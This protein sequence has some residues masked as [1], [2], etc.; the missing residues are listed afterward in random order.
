MNQTSQKNVLLA[1]V[2]LALSLSFAPTLSAHSPFWGAKA[3]NQKSLID[4]FRNFFGLQYQL[5]SGW[6]VATR[7]EDP[8]FFGL[9]GGTLAQLQMVE[10]R[11]NLEQD[12]ISFL[13]KKTGIDAKKFASYKPQVVAHRFAKMQLYDMANYSHVTKET[14]YYRLY[15]CQLRGKTYLLLFSE[16]VADGKSPIL[17]ADEDFI[18]KS[19][20]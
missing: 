12:I 15:T 16:I 2:L 6:N 14:F 20:Q 10:S 7:P 11:G 18:I 3:T 1:G 13:D 8:D 19:I 5:P 9:K 4:D 17:R